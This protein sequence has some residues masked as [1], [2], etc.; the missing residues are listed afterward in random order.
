MKNDGVT[1]EDLRVLLAVSRASSFLAAGRAIG[2]ST[3]TVARRVSVLEEHVGARLVRRA[4]SGATLEPGAR[5]LVR[6]AERIESRLASAARDLREEP[7]KFS[8]TV[9]VSLGEGFVR[10]GVRVAAAF[11]REHPETRIELVADAVVADLAKRA[12]DIALRTVKSTS[13]TLVTRKLGELRYGLYASDDYIRRRRVAL[14]SARDFAAHDF[15]VY[16]GF[17]ERQP[18]VRWLREHGAARF[19]FRAS[20]TEGV[21]EGVVA[22]QGIGAL[23]VLL[24]GAL[25]MLQRI[26]VTEDPPSKPIFIVMHRDMRAVPRLRA[27]ADALASE[28]ERVLAFGL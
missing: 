9:R 17:L 14:A 26:R 11:R 18:E 6:L 28:V 13:D 10:F 21:L 5:V 19:P 8:G 22:G 12:A 3:S 16:E 2:L 1:W 7:A 27:F 15:V 20:N 24:A 4:A 25:P 23:P